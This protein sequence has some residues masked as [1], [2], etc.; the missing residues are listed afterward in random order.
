MVALARAIQEQRDSFPPPPEIPLQ[1][2][3]PGPRYSIEARPPVAAA[4][5]YVEPLPEPIAPGRPLLPVASE[6]LERQAPPVIPLPVPVKTRSHVSVPGWLISVLVAT[7]LSLGGA[8]LIRNMETE[9]KAEAASPA[10]RKSGAAP[11]EVTALRVLGGQGSGSQLQYVVVN[12]SPTALENV[13][14]RITVRAS[15]SRASAPPL[16]AVSAAISGLGPFAA[17]EMATNIEDV[18]VADLPE[19]DR[20]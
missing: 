8:A 9:H 10:V 1:D 2:R 13:M 15:D 20:L 17:R 19:W 7:A 4:P 6:S 5:R 12:H 11:I 18:R 3:V 14:L 16:F